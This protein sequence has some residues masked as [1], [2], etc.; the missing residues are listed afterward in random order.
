MFKKSFWKSFKVHHFKR[1]AKFFLGAMLMLYPLLVFCA[2]VVFRFPLRYLSVVIILFAIVYIFINRRNYKGKHRAVIFISP[3]ILCIIGIVCLLTD[4]SLVLKL[5][6]ALADL[7]YVTI[8]GTSLYIPPPL[9][10]YFIEIFDKIFN[11]SLNKSIKGK[12]TPKQVEQY[13]RRATIAW[14]LFF[15]LD[16]MIAIFTVFWTSEFIW[17][18]Y[19][20]GI[21]YVAMGL[22]LVGEFV[23]LKIIEKRAV[24]E[25]KAKNTV[26]GA[27][28]HH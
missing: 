8:F 17:G 12:L 4:S 1:P 19:N 13:C 23:M 26:E 24:L 7:V 10:F 9:V 2:L 28:V 6:P 16:A 3:A 20:G 27:N 22:L 11:K 25:K 15:V 18:L 5:Y 21:S 14:C